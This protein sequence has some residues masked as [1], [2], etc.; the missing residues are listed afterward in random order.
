L[1]VVVSV[2][3]LPL[4]SVTVKIKVYGPSPAPNVTTGLAVFPPEIAA[5]R[6]PCAIVQE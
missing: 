2:E 5:G 4:E 1:T 6:L 3:V